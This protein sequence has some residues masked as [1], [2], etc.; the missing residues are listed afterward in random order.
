MPMH[1]TTDSQV[2]AIVIGAVF[3]SAHRDPDPTTPQS[4][5]KLSGEEHQMFMKRYEE[6]Q[7][8]NWRVGSSWGLFSMAL[9]SRYRLVVINMVHCS[10]LVHSFFFFFCSFSTFRVGYQC[11]SHYRK[12]I[13]E[14][15]LSDS[16]FT[17]DPKGEVK[18]VEGADTRGH[19]NALLQQL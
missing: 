6:F 3:M 17:L 15:K 1:I 8:N 13:K 19:V 12:L 16:S 14:G 2:L 9:P 11:A 18:L 5:R 10:L 4:E 7:C